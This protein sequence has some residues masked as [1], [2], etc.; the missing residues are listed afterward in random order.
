MNALG[1]CA[2]RFLAAHASMVLL[3]QFRARAYIEA[4]ARYRG[5]WLTACPPCSPW[6]RR[7]P[8][9]LA[10]SDLLVGRAGRHGLG[11]AH[12]GA[13]RPVKAAFPGAPVTNGYGTTETG[14]VAFGPHPRGLP[15]PDLALG[16][17]VEDVDVRLVDGDDRDA[18]EGVLEL[19]TPGAHAGLSQPARKDRRGA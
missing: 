5:T 12:A 11:A 7:R 18:D 2:R 14:P 1:T 8:T 13:D 3:P 10:R 19:R 16:Y 6:S 15:R 17:P 9:A 4:I